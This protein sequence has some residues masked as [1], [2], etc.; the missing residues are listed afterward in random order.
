M[1]IFAVRADLVIQ[2][3]VKTYVAKISYLLYR[4]QIIAIAFSQ[5]QNCTTRSEH[6]LPKM[7]E[8]HCLRVCTNFYVLLCD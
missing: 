5:R 1:L 3:G 6:L 4:A 8:W 2:N 7:R